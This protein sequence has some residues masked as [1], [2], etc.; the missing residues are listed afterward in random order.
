MKTTTITFLLLISTILCAQDFEWA[1]RAG[2]N[3]DDDIFDMVS[4]NEANIY[5]TGYFKNTAQFGEG[6]SLVSL[7]STGGADIFIAKY[8]PSGDLIWIKQ[9]GG[10][11]G[12]DWGTDISL[13]S[14]NNI[15]ITG[16]FDTE[17]SFG[18]GSSLVTLTASSDNRDIF[19]CKYTNSGELLWAYSAG[20]DFDDTGSGLS[21]DNSDNIFVVGNFKESAVFGEGGN[22]M[23]IYS[24]GGSENQDGF[25]AKYDNGGSLVWAVAYG[26]A[27]GSDGLSNIELDNQGNIFTSGYK[28]AGFLPYFDPLVVKF[29][30]NGD[31]LW[32]D[33]PT[34]VSND[35]ASGLALDHENNCYITGF[36]TI[37][38]SFG[39]STLLA[40]NE[41]GLTNIY[42]AKYSSDGNVLWAKC[43]PG[44]GGPT[45]FGGN[46]GDE[47]RDL[48]IDNHG[49]LFIT[50]YFSGITT[51]GN[52]CHTIDLI[53][54]NYKD[55]FVAKL[56]GDA[57]LQW[58]ISTGGS[59][60]QA[61]TTIC[62]G[63]GNVFLSGN[64][65][66]SAN[67]GGN[68][69][70]GFGGWSD[71]FIAKIQDLTTNSDYVKNLEA[72]ITG[73][74]G[75]ASDI[76]IEFSRAFN[77]ETVTEYR[78]FIVKSESAEDFDLESA[79]TNSFYTIVIPDGSA[80]YSI[81]PE[82]NSK[83]TDGDDVLE[84]VAY[85]IVVLSIADGTIANYNSLSCVSNEIVIPIYTGNFE[86]S[87]ESLSIYPNP[88]NGMI[89]LSGF[90]QPVKV[91][92]TDISGKTRYTERD[93]PLS[94][95]VTSS[96]QIDL[97]DFEKGIYFIQINTVNQNFTKKLII[98]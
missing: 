23:T 75:N 36:F 91:R 69:L 38:L 52:D 6:G 70:G 27:E 73:W 33:S 66:N 4:D 93:L 30:S 79:N 35:N 84:D 21:I 39:D 46:L 40:G 13:D 61:A 18:E 49:N 34:G 71:I 97:S 31:V 54:E 41:L 64:Y 95:S 14:D 47:G 2:G 80:I 42:L 89:N 58:A 5:A 78:I 26:F 3:D 17:A 32:S 62:S 92:I 50:G 72:Q 88:T 16:Y 19:I 76:T 81:N 83:D 29:D 37:D 82:E 65:Q 15:I 59:N 10:I 63:N 28:Y 87:L 77:E 43:L 11:I 86:P 67:I 57:D 68:Y 22:A 20:G 12:F 25:V 53:T 8:N 98:Q 51:F 45:P 9:A 94:S 55:I 44:T 7:T 90:S 1:T 96:L 56:N 85:K 74:S 48:S 60:N 24:A